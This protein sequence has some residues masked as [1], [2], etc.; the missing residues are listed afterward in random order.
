MPTNQL[1]G[2]PADV[3]QSYPK[4]EAVAANVRRALGLSPMAKLQTEELFE[5]LDRR[6]LGSLHQV[7]PPFASIPLRTGV[8]E[9]SA[10]AQARFDSDQGVMAIELSEAAYASMIDGY[11]RALYTFCHEL[12][13]AVLHCEQLGP[14]HA[15]ENRRGT[16]GFREKAFMF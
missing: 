12:G 3:P 5:N 16:L 7:R 4:I 15:M 2:V 9:I 6:V 10:E 11:P 13:H 8:A 1:V 14:V